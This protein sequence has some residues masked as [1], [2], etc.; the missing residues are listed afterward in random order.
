MSINLVRKIG[1][2]FQYKDIWLKVVDKEVSPGVKCLGC[3]LLTITKWQSCIGFRSEDENKNIFGFCG[4]VARK[5]GKRV[6]FTECGA[7]AIKIN[8][9]E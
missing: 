9:T 6:I 5:D 1:D 3:Y 4:P 2:V 7:P 8:L